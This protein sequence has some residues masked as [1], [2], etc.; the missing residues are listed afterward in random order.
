MMKQVT[1]LAIVCALAAVPDS[2][3]QDGRG[4][5]R[6]DVTRRHAEA[7][8]QQA[9]IDG[10]LGFV[11]GAKPAE[12]AL[13]EVDPRTYAAPPIPVARMAPGEKLQG[14]SIYVY[15]FLDV[16]DAE[17]GRKVVDQFET[18]VV[19]AL[20]QAGIRA[21][22]LRF[23]KSP[24]GAMYVSPSATS[25]GNWF[26][27][28]SYAKTDQVPVSE[29][30]TSNVADEM[31]VGARYRLLVL[32]SSYNVYGSWQYYTLRWILMDIGTGRMLW[33]HSY[34][35]KHLMLWKPDENSVK[36]AKKLVDGG[37]RELISSP[38]YLNVAAQE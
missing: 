16:R 29:V 38:L 31:A 22:A 36:R 11:P 14:S 4:K 24:A 18:Q 1:I 20:A 27:G 15:T 19:A 17:F 30:V 13:P 2:R 37:V 3:A 7:R 33:S 12:P 34:S 5:A 25:R 32:P 28:Y 10:L 23:K 9:S 35:G 21:K 8:K 6:A 26:S